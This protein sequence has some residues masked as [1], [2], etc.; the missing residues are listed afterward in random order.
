MDDFTSKDECP[1][2]NDLEEDCFNDL[3]E[4]EWLLRLFRRGAQHCQK[5]RNE[6][7]SQIRGQAR[8]AE[9][10][11]AVADFE[12]EANKDRSFRGCRSTV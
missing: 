9:E 6:I 12:S 2:A 1:R 4:V 7:T 3:R 11:K 5:V 10:Q 8:L